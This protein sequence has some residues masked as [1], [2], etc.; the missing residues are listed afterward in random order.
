MCDGFIELAVLGGRLSLATS[1]RV[2]SSSLADVHGHLNHRGQNP[3]FWLKSGL[4]FLVF[5]SASSGYQHPK[6]M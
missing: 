2:T 3:C 1:K 4:W 5:R 6:S